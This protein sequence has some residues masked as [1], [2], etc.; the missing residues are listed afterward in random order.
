MNKFWVFVAAVLSLIG[1]WTKECRA[2]SV[3]GTTDK[4]SVK[5]MTSTDE[6]NEKQALDVLVKFSMLNGWHIFA[7]NPGHIGR[8]TEVNWKLPEGYRL[9]NVRWS[10]PKDFKKGKIIQH[11]YDTTAYY[12]ATIVP[13]DRPERVQDLEVEIQWLACYEECIPEKMVR[14]LS[15]PI[16]DLNLLPGNEWRNEMQTAQRS[17]ETSDL[18]V[19]A[20]AYNL[21]LILVMAFAGGVILNFMPC[22]FPILTIKAISL[23]QG[24]IKPKQ[25]RQEALLYTF[26]VVLSFLITAG[27]LLFLR[28]QGE[29]VGWG[30]Q[31]QSPLFVGIMLA[32]FIVVFL[33]LMDWIHLPNLF[34]DKLGRVTASKKKISAFATGFFAVLIASPCTA[35][36]MGIAIGYTLTQPTYVYF[37]VFIAL[38][39]GYALP[40]AL[41]GFFPKAVH[42]MLPRPGKW[43]AILKKIFAIPVLLTCLW[44]VWVLQSQLVLRSAAGG[45]TANLDW[46]AYNK[47][48]V[49][50][51]VADGHAVFVD[52]TAKW[53]ITCLANESL[54][55]N[56]KDFEKLVKD[57]NILLFKADWTNDDPEITEALAAFGR[58]SVPLYVYY[59]GKDSGYVI[60]PQLLTYKQVKSYLDK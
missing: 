40:F 52:F 55:L 21:L 57:K 51:L 43:M 3:E 18:P 30:F 58:N 5:V 48:K 14:T 36:F 49:E 35:P 41:V 10:K 22:I 13:T 17:F 46:E 37:P 44:L 20:P 15:L 26:G 1:I 45:G 16:T 23:V 59:S 9:E 27:I 60:L 53:C 42:K 47:A 33:L 12:T 32:V 31:L 56:S 39:L 25:M 28:W 34:A 4:V 7:Q 54:V 2:L 24:S 8:P 50:K 38:A 11:G 29:Q 19:D 6:I